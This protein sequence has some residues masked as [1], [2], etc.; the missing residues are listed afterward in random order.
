MNVVDTAR[1]QVKRAVEKVADRRPMSNLWTKSGYA[2]SRDQ[3]RP[4]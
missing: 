2:L 3:R 1:A 4:G